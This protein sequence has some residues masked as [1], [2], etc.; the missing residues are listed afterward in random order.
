[1]WAVTGE[2]SSFDRSLSQRDNGKI[3]HITGD[4]MSPEVT[5]SVSGVDVEVRVCPDVFRKPSSLTLSKEETALNLE[6]TFS[7][8][9]I[10]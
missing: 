5:V 1:M 8:H 9:W 7:S 4:N 6:F 2:A 10:H 3:Q